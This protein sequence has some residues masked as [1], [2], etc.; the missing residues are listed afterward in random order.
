MHIV[1]HMETRGAHQASSLIS[2]SQGLSLN[3][4]STFHFFSQAVRPADA[5]IL[6]LFSTSSSSAGITGVCGHTRFYILEIGTQVL[7]FPSSLIH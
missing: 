4:A 3:L 2:L 5:A 6:V 1:T 7:M